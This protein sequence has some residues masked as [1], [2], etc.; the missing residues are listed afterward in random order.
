MDKQGLSMNHVGGCW[1]MHF[2]YI[3]A[4][5]ILHLIYIFITVYIP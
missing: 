5:A 2:S 3:F 4:C 1:R